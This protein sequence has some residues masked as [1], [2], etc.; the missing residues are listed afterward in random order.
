[1]ESLKQRTRTV[2][3]AELVKD[4][5]HLQW[6]RDMGKK[7]ALTLKVLQLQKEH[8]D[9]VEMVQDKLHRYVSEAAVESTHEAITHFSNACLH[10]D[11]L[12]CL[13]VHVIL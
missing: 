7:L 8:A 2:E 10:H 4:A 13:L 5:Q 3:D 9:K 12:T 6:Q 11:P 1:M